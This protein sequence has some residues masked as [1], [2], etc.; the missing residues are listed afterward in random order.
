MNL[1]VMK[2]LL[3]LR[4]WLRCAVALYLFLTTATAY[5]AS[6]SEQLIAAYRNNLPLPHF[7]KQFPDADIS[8]AY[9]V[10]KDLVRAL[11]KGD[12]IAG[13]KAGLTSLKGQ[14]KFSVNQPLSGVLMEKGRVSSRV[15]LELESYRKLMLETE[16]A[17]I[18]AKPLSKPVK[19]VEQL[20]KYVGMIAPAIELP[21]LGFSPGTITGHDLVAANVAARAFML[22]EA[23][24]IEHVSDL[25]NL[26][27]RLYHNDKLVSEGLGNEAMGDQWQALLW[28]VNQILSQG[29]RIEAGQ[30]VITGTIGK[31]LSALPGHY[32]ADFAEL[33]HLDFDVTQ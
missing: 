31:L 26:V 22:G 27:I 21:D 23:Q 24:P 5:A 32:R 14:Q 17:Y 4:S 6:F 12:T 8:Q 28:L 20:K 2:R 16:I 3:H 13:F 25:N 1:T 29:Y 10:Q 19:S 18:F 33:G 11:R 7:S 15:A 9:R 30:F